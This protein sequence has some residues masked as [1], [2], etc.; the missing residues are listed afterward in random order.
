MLQQSS[1][2]SLETNEK[3]RKSQQRDN[4]NSLQECITTLNRIY[5]SV[6]NVDFSKA[7]SLK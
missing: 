2:N 5:Y 3:N 6:D 4:I 7:K 1:T